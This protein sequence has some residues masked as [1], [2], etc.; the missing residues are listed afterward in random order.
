[1]LINVLSQ[2]MLKRLMLKIGLIIQSRAKQFYCCEHGF[3]ML[4][5]S[6]VGSYPAFASSNYPKWKFCFVIILLKFALL[7]KLC[8]QELIRL[9]TLED[10]RVAK[11]LC[12]PVFPP[13]YLILDHFMDLYHE[14]LSNRV[15]DNKTVSVAKIYSDEW[16]YFTTKFLNIFFQDLPTKTVLESRTTLL[17]D[18][19]TLPA[20]I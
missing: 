3:A 16:Q 15:S 11:T 8:S 19:Q 13:S 1:M 2:I 10:L 7:C 9:I 14:A 6:A 12:Q 5:K 4:P 20:P 17:T 18:P